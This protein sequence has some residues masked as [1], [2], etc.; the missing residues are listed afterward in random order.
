MHP[1]DESDFERTKLAIDCVKHITTLATGTIVFSAAI[2]ERLPKPKPHLM[3]MFV[4]S[5]GLT[6]ISLLACFVYLFSVGVMPHWRGHEPT[7][8]ILGKVGVVIYFSFALGLMSLG[9]YV[10]FTVFS[11]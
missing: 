6:V 8:E 5:I 4:F 3:V 7:A 10:V 9:T 1:K 11:Q 2:I